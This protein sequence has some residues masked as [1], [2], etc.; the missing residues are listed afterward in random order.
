MSS[1][2]IYALGLSAAGI[3]AG[4]SGGTNVTPSHS[5]GLVQNDREAA[6]TA[7]L[8][9][10]A[11]GFLNGEVFKSHNVSTKIV[12]GS[13]HDRGGYTVDFTATGI[14]G[15]PYLGKLTATGSWGFHSCNRS[16]REWFFN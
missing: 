12:H 1:S 10:P 15:G 14:A 13:C 4:C 3:L 2:F 16:C 5:A 11:T 6:V 9:K 8:L 7:P